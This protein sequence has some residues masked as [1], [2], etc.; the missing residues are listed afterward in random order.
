MLI[1]GTT[2]TIVEPL[3]MVVEGID[4]AVTLRAVFRALQAMS[5]A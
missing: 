4:A 1:V 2:D 3:A 5:L